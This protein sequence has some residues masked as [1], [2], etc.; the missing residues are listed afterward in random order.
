MSSCEYRAS[1]TFLIWVGPLQQTLDAIMDRPRYARETHRQRSEAFQA[2]REHGLEVRNAV[3]A[4]RIE[5]NRRIRDVM[6]RKSLAAANTR[7]VRERLVSAVDQAAHAYADKAQEYA[8]ELRELPEGIQRARDALV[9]E[10]SKAAASLRASK[11]T[12]WNQQRHEAREAISS[13]KRRVHDEVR[14]RCRAIPPEMDAQMRRFG[15]GPYAPPSLSPVKCGVAA[16]HVVAVEAAEEMGASCE[17][18]ALEIGD[19]A[20]GA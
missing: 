12:H 13:S 6:R 14:A 2:R 20:F 10:R 19:E 9:G 18:G 3:R 8:K 16:P 11:A 5:A 1:F 4:Q 15:I 7:Y 17:H